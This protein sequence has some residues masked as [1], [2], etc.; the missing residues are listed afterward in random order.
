MK[1]FKELLYENI[2]V[3]DKETRMDIKKLKSILPEWSI[4]K[5]ISK[6]RA[7]NILA[8]DYVARS[9]SVPYSVYDNEDDFNDYVLDNRRT[10]KKFADKGVNSYI[11]YNKYIEKE[12]KLYKK[13]LQDK[14]DDIESYGV[15]VKSKID[16]DSVFIKFTNKVKRK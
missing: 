4:E 3:D 10:K 13:D 1:T 7:G 8:T 16:K 5:K 6:D 15:K 9:N 2:I 12:L 14:I 11:D